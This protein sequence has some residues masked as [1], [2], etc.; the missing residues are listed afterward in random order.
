MKTLLDHKKRQ[1]ATIHILKKELQ[2]SESDY[3]LTM[4][5]IGNQDSASKLTAL[6]RARV[7]HALRARLSRLE[8]DNG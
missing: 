6:G 1:L 5:Q 4:L 3:R 8:T 2:M 7:I